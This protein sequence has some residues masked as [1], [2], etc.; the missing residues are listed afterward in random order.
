MTLYLNGLLK[1]KCDEMSGRELISIHQFVVLVILTTIGDAIL[2]LPSTVTNDAG[3]D[4][5]LSMILA[6]AIGL[7]IVYLFIAVGSFY[8]K[9]TII[10]YNNQILGK[11]IGPIISAFFLGYLFLSISVYVRELGDF[12]TTKILTQTPIQVIYFLF[13]IIIILGVRSGL[14][15]IARTSEFLFPIIIIVLIILLTLVLSHVHIDWIRPIME[16]GVKPLLK[17]T[18]VA[19]AFPF[20]ELV[21]FLMILPS[22]SQQDKIK[23]GFFIGTLIGGIIL[24]L[25][26]LLCIL[27]LGETATSK[28]IYPT[29]TLAKVINI[30]GIIQRI[31]GVIAIIWVLTV[32]LKITLYTYALHIGLANLF[33]LDEYRILTLPIGMI[34]FSSASLVAPNISYLNKV[35]AN[36]WPF[37]VF[38]VAVLLPI[39]LISVS[40]IRKKLNSL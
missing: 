18:I 39:I 34:I 13:I 5:W 20:M 25:V 2:V 17:G 23:S 21:V 38:T 32:Y 33:K 11:W 31:E 9:L 16:N 4:A 14:E 37:Y 27:V 28:N 19:T 29:F 36:Y 30:D 8:P 15:T 7:L 12:I 3:K 22:I 26:I 6:I 40:A 35:I 10:Q 24:F 1:E